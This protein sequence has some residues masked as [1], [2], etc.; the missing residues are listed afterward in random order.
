M[1]TYILCEGAFDA[2]LLKTVLPEN[3]LTDVGVVVGGKVYNIKSLAMSLIVRRRVPVLIVFDADSVVPELVELRRNDI[4]EILKFV[5]GKTP[6]KV[7]SA[8]PEIE[9]IFFQDVSL[10]SRLIGYIP[11]QDV[12]DLAVCQPR[13]ALEELI[14]RSENIH[15]RSQIIDHLTNED[16]EILRSSSVMQEI[17]HFL[18]SVRETVAA[19]L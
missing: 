18:D 8:V 3:L 9:I 1:I 13:K 19:T 5:A 16:I 6:F 2:Q 17:V 14:A 4:E 12:L 10:L 11:P 15:D 7:V